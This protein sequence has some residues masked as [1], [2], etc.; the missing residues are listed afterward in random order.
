MPE[1]DSDGN[2]ILPDDDDDEDDDD[3]GQ[4]HYDSDGND[5]DF[6]GKE[7]GSIKERQPDPD[8]G[9]PMSDIS[10]PAATT[11]TVEYESAAPPAEPPNDSESD[12]M[13]ETSDVEETELLRETNLL[14]EENE[15]WMRSQG[16][17]IPPDELIQPTEEEEVS[18]PPADPPNDSNN[19]NE[20]IEIP[21]EGPIQ[22]KGPIEPTVEDDVV[23]PPADP[24][25]SPNDLEGDNIS[26]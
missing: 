8:D 21:P 7:E 2:E 11:P 9:Y 16:L 1:Y 13:S 24:P 14:I 19:G 4:P 18:R 17:A 26:L 20:G 15:E 22:P 5:I 6:Q 3:E 10:D 23:P 12:D 25:N